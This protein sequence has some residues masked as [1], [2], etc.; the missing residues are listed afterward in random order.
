[1]ILYFYPKDD[2]PGCTKEACGFRDSW[3]EFK[4]K[5]AVVLGVKDSSDAG[6]KGL[7]K[8]DVIMRA[9][10]TATNTP[11]EVSSAAPTWPRP[12]LFTSTSIR[13]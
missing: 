12:A 10:E 1:M 13:P 4:K 9:G 7:Q 11:S 6:D 3:D 5:G 2:T 8:G